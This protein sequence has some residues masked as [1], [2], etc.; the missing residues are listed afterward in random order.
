MEPPVKVPPLPPLLLWRMF[1]SSQRLSYP[2]LPSHLFSCNGV[3]GWLLLSAAEETNLLAQDHPESSGWGAASSLWSSWPVYCLEHSCIWR[4]LKESCE[5]SH[6][7]GMGPP[8]GVM[9]FFENGLS[10]EVEG[11]L[12]LIKNF[13]TPP[14]LVVFWVVIPDHQAAYS[15]SWSQHTSWGI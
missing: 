4:V 6:G 12:G 7:T 14:S 1:P 13:R 8:L 15:P 3:Q 9:R 5:Y 10:T 2:F 11:R